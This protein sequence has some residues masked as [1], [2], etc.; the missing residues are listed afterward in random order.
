[1]L[2]ERPSLVYKDGDA[3]ILETGLDVV[4]IRIEVGRDDGD[5]AVS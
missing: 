5:V 1:M 4:F 2:I 3:V